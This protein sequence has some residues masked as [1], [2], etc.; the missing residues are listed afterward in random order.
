MRPTDEPARLLEL[1]VPGGFEHYF[2]ELGE[3][4]G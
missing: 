2:A 1:I 3:I 4:L